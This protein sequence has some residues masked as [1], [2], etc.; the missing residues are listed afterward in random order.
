[1]QTPNNT[2]CGIPSWL[3]EKKQD[4]TE[5]IQALGTNFIAKSL[6]HFSEVFENEFFCERY[7]SKSMMLQCLDP[8]VKVIVLFGFMLFS[9][10]SSSIVILLALAVIALIYAK[11][12]G[13]DMKDYVRRVWAYIP[14]IIF[15]FSIP[16]A[17]SLFTKGTPLFYILRP[18]VFGLQTGLYFTASGI[19]M[20]VRLAL[21]PGI[22]LSFAFL[23]LLT[24]RWTRI[25]G[26]LASM[27]LPLLLVS[28]LNMAYRYIFVMSDMAGSMLEARF[29]RTVGKLKTTDNRQFMSRS[30]AS[31][32]LKSHALSE[33]IYDAMLCRG[34][35][36]KPV[37]VDEFK[38]G[39]ADI[40]FI[41]NN[42]VII[43]VLIA[44]ERLF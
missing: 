44:G 6:H 32:F 8:R 10:F 41:I 28:I 33:E 23:L 13:L 39:A 21:R 1:V 43:I 40:L 7:A 17:S 2:D 36:G 38:I 15:I 11:L 27:H 16:G 42:I 9:A 3:L 24:T 25:T 19:G 22:S 31:L 29:L 5:K 4:G 18:G 20:A 30:V 34:F 12:S 14:L 26:A 37:S 35:T